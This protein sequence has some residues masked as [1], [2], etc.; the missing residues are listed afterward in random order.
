VSRAYGLLEKLR[1]YSLENVTFL[2]K[3]LTA[4]SSDK[5]ML[6]RMVLSGCRT[7]PWL[8]R[9]TIFLATGHKN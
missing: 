2:Q 8:E 6:R 7:V 5:V 3:L 4:K 1:P 9:G